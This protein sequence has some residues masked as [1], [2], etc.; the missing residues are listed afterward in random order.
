[1][2]KKVDMAELITIIIS[3]L[4]VVVMSLYNLSHAGYLGLSERL[5]KFV[6]VI[7]ENGFLIM[8]CAMIGLMTFGVLKYLFH[9]VF[10][11]YFFLRLIYHTSC[12]C[13]VYIVSAEVWE[14]MWSVVLVVLLIFGLGYTLFKL[15]RHA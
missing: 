12:Y 11:P 8:L 6:W 5:W 14:K 13:G 9:V 4:F 3:L 2:G 7:A 10:I 15:K 1:M